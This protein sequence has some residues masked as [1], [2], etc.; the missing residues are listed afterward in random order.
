MLYNYRMR[1]KPHFNFDNSFA[2]S[3]EGF[4]VS[5]QAEPAVALKLLQFNHALADGLTRFIGFSGHNRPARFVK[6]LKNFQADVLLNAVNFVDRLTYNFE[7]S[8]WPLASRLKMGL[9]AMKVF[10]GEDKSKNIKLSHSFMPVEYHDLAFRYALSIPGTASIA[11]GMATRVELHQNIKRAQI[12]KPIT[13]FEANQ[14]KKI[15]QQLA[16]NWGPHLGAVT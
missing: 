11:I 12:F 2:R 5:C 1:T 16:K 13:S 8:V 14:L 15:G 7:E 9:I 4:F 10:G 3:L 6:A